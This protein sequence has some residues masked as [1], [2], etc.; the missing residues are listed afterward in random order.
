VLN[1]GGFFDDKPIGAQLPPGRQNRPEDL[2]HPFPIRCPVHFPAQQPTQKVMRLLWEWNIVSLCKS[3]PMA[4][5]PCKMVRLFP[6]QMT[7]ASPLC[8][9]FRAIW[10]RRQGGLLS[11]K[12]VYGGHLFESSAWTTLPRDEI[13]EAADTVEPQA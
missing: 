11:F 9:F 5:A 8:I 2:A 13:S 12:A 1:L 4:R 3:Q 6:Q 7:A 10:K